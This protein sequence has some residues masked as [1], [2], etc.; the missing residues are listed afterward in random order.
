MLHSN[1]LG[2]LLQ[3]LIIA[4]VPIDNLT[5]EETLDRVIELARMGREDDRADWLQL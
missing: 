5:M 1:R 4:G 3:L 2:I